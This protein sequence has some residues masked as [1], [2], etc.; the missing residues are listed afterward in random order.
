[1]EKATQ[2]STDPQSW[3]ENTNITE[4]TQEIAYL[5]SIN[6]NKHQPQSPS[7]G[8]L[9]YWTIVCIAFYESYLSTHSV[10]CKQGTIFCAGRKRDSKKPS[11]ALWYHYEQKSYY[12]WR[13]TF[14]KIGCQMWH[15]ENFETISGWPYKKIK[16]SP[17]II[18]Q[19]MSIQKI[20]WIDKHLAFPSIF[21][22]KQEKNRNSMKIW[23]Q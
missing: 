20:P 6:S 15:Y 1:M 8:K 2:K 21:S 23:S 13:I 22:G 18:S 9:F 10:E 14:Q 4:S 5:Q 11:F 3:V 12:A 16:N 17:N 7:T 19:K